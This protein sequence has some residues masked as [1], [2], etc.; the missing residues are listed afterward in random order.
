MFRSRRKPCHAR[1]I[2]PAC[3]TTKSRWASH[4]AAD[5]KAGTWQRQ[6]AA[7]LAVLGQEVFAGSG[8]RSVN[9]RRIDIRAFDVALEAL[10]LTREQQEC[11]LGWACLQE[12]LDAARHAA[13]Y[14]QE[15][16][17]S[18]GRGRRDRQ[19]GRT[20]GKKAIQH[21]GGHHAA[22]EQRRET[23]A[24]A[25]IAELGEHERDGLILASDG[26]ADAQRAIEGFVNEPRHF[27]VVG[28]GESR[29]EIGLQREFPEQRQTERVD[30]A[31]VDVASAIAELAPAGGRD[32]APFHR[33]TQRPE[34][35][36]AHLRGR[37]PRER[38]GEDVGGIDACAQ[39][40]DVPVDE[41]ARLAGSGGRL[42]RHVE[43]WVNGPLA[44][45]TIALGDPAFDG[46]LVVERQL[47]ATRHS[48]CGR[49]T[50][51]RSSCRSWDR[52]DEA[53]TR[54]R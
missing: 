50:H 5:A 46:V 43:S 23:G 45:G 12:P 26:A 17:A 52:E 37:L 7:R 13:K 31:D 22:I 35:A 24:G 32:V 49:P 19:R 30:R 39:Q 51:T 2:S 53:E 8:K 36:L 54:R 47:I 34:D 9:R 6:A 28:H 27:H 3:P 10:Q 18:V 20:S 41:H 21:G 15:C 33:R 42:E 4:V 16:G 25:T 11:G 38:D 1:R 44:S 29:I 48:P 14:R 40:V